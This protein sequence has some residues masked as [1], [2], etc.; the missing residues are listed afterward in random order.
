MK[1]KGKILLAWG[2]LLAI[3]ILG[4]FFQYRIEGLCTEIEHHLRQ[5][6]AMTAAPLKEAIE[7]WE[8]HQK[9]LTALVTHEEVDAVRESLRRAMAFLEADNAEEYAAALSEARADLTVV[10]NFDQLTIRSIF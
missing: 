4:F 1:G 5:A 3:P 8:D 6:E 9:L 2:I 7:L 10:R